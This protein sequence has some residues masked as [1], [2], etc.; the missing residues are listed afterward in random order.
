MSETVTSSSQEQSTLSGDYTTLSTRLEAAVRDQQSGG[1]VSERMRRLTE[2]HELAEKEKAAIRADID[3]NDK[4]QA[5]IESSL[6]DLKDEILR[7]LIS[8]KDTSTVNHAQ[9][10]VWNARLVELQTLHALLEG[11]LSDCEEYIAKN[12]RDMEPLMIRGRIVEKAIGHAALLEETLSELPTIDDEPAAF[13]RQ[14]LLEP[15]TEVIVAADA[16]GGVTEVG[17]DLRSFVS[18]LTGHGD[19][20]SVPIIIPAH[21]LKEPIAV[22]PVEPEVIPIQYRRRYEPIEPPSGLKGV[23]KKPASDKINDKKARA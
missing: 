2:L 5:L 7:V 18:S 19:T 17:A 3:A 1:V 13:S 16:E 21:H 10:V 22:P 23:L 8:G 12:R 14:P 9:A 15:L 11:E 4:E 6:K 20:V